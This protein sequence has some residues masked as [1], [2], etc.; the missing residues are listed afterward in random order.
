MNARG[1][2]PRYSR[3]P[4]C[5]A[6]DPPTHRMIEGHHP[7]A[8][9]RLRN[10]PFSLRVVDAAKLF[11][12]GELVDG[13]A[14]T[15]K[16]KTLSFKRELNSDRPHVVNA[17]LARFMG[18]IDGAARLLESVGARLLFAGLKV[19]QLTLDMRKSLDQMI[20]QAHGTPPGLA[21]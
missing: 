13:T 15:D 3:L 14:M 18:R 4:I 11:L 5:L 1:W 2:L 21:M 16:L 8:A 7:C 9:C 20:L 10:Q 12:I 6:G 19:I 17:N